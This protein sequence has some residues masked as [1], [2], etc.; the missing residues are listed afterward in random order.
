MKIQFGKWNRSVALDSRGFTLV[1]L[2]VVV[3][4]IGIL[5]AVA[6]PQYAKFQAKSRQAEV[7]VA[8]AAIHGAEQAY[9]GQKGSITTCLGDA[10]YISEGR[11]RYYNVG[12]SAAQANRTVCGPTGGMACH[13]ADW[14][15]QT[16][17]VRNCGATEFGGAV[18]AATDMNFAGVIPANP[19][20]PG[21]AAT[22]KVG[23]VANTD[24][25]TAFLTAPNLLITGAG[26]TA[27]MDTTNTIVNQSTFTAGGVGNVA[28][29]ATRDI[30][31]ID[32]RKNLVN[33]QS[34]I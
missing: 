4:I 16:N 26:L 1:E 13:L 12:F 23:S 24:L 5:A 6:L 3:A 31:V 14:D 28:N 27:G 25:G 8:L 10:G 11:T 21:Y 22:A 9:I 2:M 32:Q 7:G 33:L 17:Q 34:G 29:T 19:V 18:T 20:S 15:A 30:W